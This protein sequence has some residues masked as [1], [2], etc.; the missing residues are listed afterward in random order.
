MRR[1]LIVDDEKNI[2]LGLKA[3]IEREYPGM[4]AIKTA[5][6]GAEAWERCLRMHAEI[7]ITDIRMPEMDGIALIQSLAELDAGPH[8]VILSG[9]DDF[10]YAK[11]AIKYGVKDYLLKPIV[12]EELRRALERIDREMA[13]NERILEKLEAAEKQAEE[14]RGSLLNYIVINPDLP[15]RELED[16]CEQVRLRD[17]AGQYYV[18]LIKLWSD[19]FG[20]GEGTM[21]W[22]LP[23]MYDVQTELG[24]RIVHF[25]DNEGQ[26]VV[27]ADDAEF[28]T[29][30]AERMAKPGHIRCMIGLS[31]KGEDVTLLRQYYLQAQKALKYG[32]LR[33]EPGLIPYERI[34][35]RSR[36]FQ[37]PMEQIR[38]LANM[39][40]TDREEDMN[41]LLRDIFDMEKIGRYDIF[42]VEEIGAMLNEHVFDRVLHMYGEESAQIAGAYRKVKNIYHFAGFHDY[43]RSVQNLLFQ[44]NDYVRH[45]VSA[46][47]EHKEMKKAVQYIQDHYDKD[48]NMATVSNYVSLNYTYFSQ[49]FKEYTGSNF[50]HY[51]KRVRVSKAKELLARTNLRIGEVGRMVGFEHAKHF[52]RVF[53][54]IE[55]ISATE[56]RDKATIHISGETGEIRM[57]CESVDR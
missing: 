1:L 37:L 10:Q 30:L 46:H 12:R 14:I 13:Q 57:P 55:G 27:I 50:V 53:R 26:P 24:C 40:G 7:V 19:K 22:V 2:R 23:A 16:I 18:G 33:P 3:M 56:Y 17:F 32:L 9:Y 54:E 36:D 31:G 43:Y 8:I 39:L 49:A 11:E 28:V 4:Y 29:G 52:N 15:Q 20:E 38:K 42:Y 51:L 41:G 21:Q 5:S 35:D 25:C 34:R 47:A 48:L 45:V 6:D 44:L